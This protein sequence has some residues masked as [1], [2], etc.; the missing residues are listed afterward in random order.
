MSR[1][2]IF[3][4]SSILLILCFVPLGVK[5]PLGIPYSMRFYNYSFLSLGATIGLFILVLLSIYAAIF[6]QDAQKIRWIYAVLAGLFTAA[7]IERV[8]YLQRLYAK[9]QLH[10]HPT[11]YI[12][13]G[14]NILLLLYIGYLLQRKNKPTSASNILDDLQL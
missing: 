6:K 7:N 1:A 8:F 4:F 10:L 13:I 5:D 9:E 11:Y 2:I 3:I 14:F 12:S